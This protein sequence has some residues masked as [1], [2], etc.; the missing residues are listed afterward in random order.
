VVEMKK[1]RADLIRFIKNKFFNLAEIQDEAED[2]VNE[3]F[4]KACIRD[5]SDL[6]FRYLLSVAINIAIDRYKQKKR[7]ISF[8]SVE[9]NFSDEC[10]ASDMIEDDE[11]KAKL[12]QALTILKEVESMII[13]HYFFDELS[14]DQI[15]N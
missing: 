4:L 5:F 10:T 8:D 6:N 11:K 7:N 15:S 9:H 12:Y 1:L 13:K 3:A 14:F 2:I